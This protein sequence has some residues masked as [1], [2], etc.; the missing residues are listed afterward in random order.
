MK[1]ILPETLLVIDLG[2]FRVY[3]ARHTADSLQSI[4]F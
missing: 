1:V 4:T 3:Y 2:H